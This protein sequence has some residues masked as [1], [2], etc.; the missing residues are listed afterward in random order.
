MLSIVS[1]IFPLIEIASYSTG[2]SVPSS[3]TSDSN[4]I[5]KEQSNLNPFMIKAV[6]ACIVIDFSTSLWGI[7][8]TFPVA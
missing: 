7:V 5:K 6:I 8:L 1:T 2:L 4:S 3:D